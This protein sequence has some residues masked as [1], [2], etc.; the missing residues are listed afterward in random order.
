M[1]ASDRLQAALLYCTHGFSVIPFRPRSKKPAFAKREILGY[2]RKSASEAQVR[3][4]FAH[5]DKNVG[6]ITGSISRLLVLDID[7]EPGEQS[8]KGL[9]MPPTPT[10]MT[11]RPGRQT[12][13]R[14]P[15]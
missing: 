11:P 9:P 10:V 8:I 4:W 15:D 7:G 13:F 5:T 2:R 6:F 14:E 1:S 12:Y 3:R